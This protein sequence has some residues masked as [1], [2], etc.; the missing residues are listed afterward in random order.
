MQRRSGATA[1]QP[2]AGRSLTQLRLRSFEFS[3]LEYISIESI[4]HLRGRSRT[5]LLC[6]ATLLRLAPWRSR[7]LRPLRPGQ[8]GPGKSQR[9]LSGSISDGGAAARPAR[10]RVAARRPRPSRSRAGHSRV[11]LV[12]LMPGHCWR[13]AAVPSSRSAALSLIQY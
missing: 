9:R 7:P 11:H 3:T 2:T 4:L 8:L 13:L 5:V 10:V 12:V 1:A 6:T